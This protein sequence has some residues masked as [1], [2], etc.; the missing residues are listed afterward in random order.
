[1]NTSQSVCYPL[2]MTGSARRI[3]NKG[4]QTAGMKLHTHTHTHQRLW[5]GAEWPL[6]Y[7]KFSKQKAISPPVLV[8][9][10]TAVLTLPVA[11]RTEPYRPLKLYTQT[12]IK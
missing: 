4:D 9:V 11:E 7:T 12:H 10:S 5:I 6:L 8:S 3:S 1:M 2:S